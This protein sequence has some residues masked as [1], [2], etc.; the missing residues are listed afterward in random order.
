MKKFYANFKSVVAAVVMVSMTLAASCSYD[1]SAIVER[2]DRVEKDLAALTERVAAL[3]KRLG[4]E[5]EA[6]TALINGKV[7]VT[8]VEK[9]GDATKVTLSDGSSFTVYPECTVVDTDT[10]TNTY[11]SIAEENGVLYF[12]VYEKGEFKEWLLVNG[13]KVPVYDGNDQ[14]D[15][16]CDDPYQPEAPVAPQFKVEGEN[17]M[18]SI[19]GGQTWVESGLS[20][21]AAGAQIF[22]GVEVNDDN[23]VTFKL[24]DGSQFDVMLAELI[25]FANRGHIYVKAGEVKEVAL[26]VNDAVADIN[27]MNQPLGWKAE[28]ALAPE[29]EEPEGGDEVVPD[30]GV[31]AA[32]GTDYIIKVYG[33]SKDLVKAGVADQGGV[34]QV[35]FNTATGA[36]KV[37]KLEVDLAQLTLDV[38]KMGNIH[39][40]NSLVSTYEYSDWWTGETTLLTDFNNYYAGVMPLDDYSGDLQYDINEAWKDCAAG[41]NTNYGYYSGFY[42]EDGVTMYEASYYEDGVCEIDILNTTVKAFVDNFS[43]GAFDYEGN[44]FL[45][46]AVPVDMN[47]GD[48]M[49]DEAILKEFKQL[50]VT[51][52][53][54]EEKFNNVYFDVKLRGAQQYQINVMAKAQI[55]SYIE[56]GYAETMEDYFFSMA[57]N[58]FQQPAWA[59][60]GYKIGTDVVE[61]GIDVNELLNYGASYMQY[62]E[63]APNTEYVMAILAEEEGK[64]AEEYVKEDI[65]YVYFATADI[66]EAEEPFEYSVE[67]NLELKDYFNIAVN[68]TVPDTSAVV[69]SA[70]YSEEQ[71][72]LDALKADLIANGWAKID[73]ESG[74]TYSLSSTTDVAGETKYLGLLIVDAEGNYTIGQHE[75]SSR[76]VIYN[77]ATISIESVEFTESSATVTVAGVDGL[78]VVG[79]KTYIVRNDVNSYYQKTQ[80]QLADLGYKTNWMYGE[81]DATNPIVL[82]KCADNATQ[83]VG[84]KTYKVAVVA[85]FSDGSISNTAYGEYFYY[86]GAVDIE[87]TKF[88]FMG[89]YDD[90]YQTGWTGGNGVYVIRGTGF[91]AEISV[92]YNFRNLETGAINEGTYT[93]AGNNNNLVYGTDATFSVNSGTLGDAALPEGM[94]GSTMTVTAEGITLNL[95]DAEGRALANVTYAGA[96]TIYD[97][98]ASGNWIPTSCSLSGSFSDTYHWLYLDNGDFICV[99]WYQNSVWTSSTY[100]KNNGGNSDRY[101]VSTVGAF[102]FEDNGDGTMTYINVDLTFED[103]TNIQFSNVTLEYEDNRNNW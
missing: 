78:D 51:V 40:T 86:A 36:C 43:Y 62:F 7:V 28:V 42:G 24:A 35:H 83:F 26:T 95:F 89:G 47:T 67:E 64:A 32:G 33:P 13:E 55:D 15:D 27:I 5:V 77:E 75:F 82:T 19:D 46:F 18:V 90:Y 79:Y 76:A 68:V 54:A 94:S 14:D 73:F 58:Y 1:D 49:W 63:L 12:A 29:T 38:D 80:E 9:V 45:V 71:M 39:I 2:V 41:F 102:E 31:L 6:L 70:W 93:Y 34:I 11:I 20:A 101:L 92:N 72:E 37:G 57:L 50:N 98:S 85:L 56:W 52:D 21:A 99:N 17:I 65:K 100:Y 53:V 81:Q 10:D 74:Y 84:G 25:E 60:F 23:T 87:A 96:P 4:E 48:Q 103:G 88:V 61:Q 59:Q 16:V 69:Y 8:G 3:E 30:M 97:N 44:S 22:S 91:K 66:F